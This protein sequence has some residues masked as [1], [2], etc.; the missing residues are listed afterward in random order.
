MVGLQ[1]G[2]FAL[3]KA[4]ETF[5]CSCSS[6]ASALLLLKLFGYVAVLRSPCSHVCFWAVFTHFFSSVVQVLSLSF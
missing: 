5:D 1:E 4:A 6:T 2:D 3:E